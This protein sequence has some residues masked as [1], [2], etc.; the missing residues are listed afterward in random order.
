MPVDEPLVSVIIPT[1]NRPDGL[2]RAL[3]SVSAQTFRDF[4]VI[5]VNDA[6]IPVEQ[7]VAE[8]G[9]KEQTYYIVSVRKAN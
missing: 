4:E 8:A 1:Y 9:P 5:V 6:G 7:V 2:R 3:A